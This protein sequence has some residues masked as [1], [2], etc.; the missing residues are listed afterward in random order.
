M[1]PKIEPSE[2]IVKSLLYNEQKVTIHQAECILAENFLKDVDRLTWEDKVLRFERRQQLNERVTTSQHISLNFDPADKL[3][4][5]KM[6][7]IART[8]M[9]ELGFERQPY[10]VYRHYDSGHPHCHIVTTHIQANGDPIPQYKIGENQSEKARIYIEEKFDLVT[11]EKK[12]LNQHL[13][14]VPDHILKVHYGE[15]ATT[16]SISDTVHYVMEKYNCTNL[17]EFNAVLRLYNVEADP[18]KENSRLRQHHGLLYRV[19]DEQGH[20]IGR[21]IKASFFDFKP[22][23]RHLEEKFRL[24]ETLR[25]QQ[26]LHERIELYVAWELMSKKMT[27]EKLSTALTRESIHMELKKD[28]AGNITDVIYVDLHNQC[29]IQ[30]D[31]LQESCQK[32]SLQKLSLV[33]H[34]ETDHLSHRHRH[35]LS[36]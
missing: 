12:R 15:R 23:L 19:L 6:Q 35:H 10:L 9:K 31:A 36:L 3:S 5:E 20:Y 8:Y 22:T 27:L 34:I 32:E 29:A 18:G 26:H 25:Q 24:N 13:S 33:Q 21:P 11:A 17:K 28:K 2:S 16:P 1:L 4:N 30:G 14:Q 7:T